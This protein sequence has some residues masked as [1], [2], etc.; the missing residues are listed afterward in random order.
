MKN[1]LLILFLFMSYSGY[2]YAAATRAIQADLW[3]SNDLSKTFT[4]P[5]V[6]DTLVGVSAT[7]TIQGKTMS[8]TANTFSNVA[9]G[10]F[11]TGN[12]SGNASATSGVQATTLLSNFVG[13][14]GSGGTKGLVPAPIAGDSGKYLKGDGTWGTV[15]AGVGDMVLA[16]SQTVTGAKSFNLNTLLLNGTT[17]S[18]WLNGPAAGA[19]GTVTLP[20][21]GTV[22]TLAGTETLTNKTVSTSTIIV[23]DDSLTIQD[24]VTPTKKLQLQVSSVTAGN[25]RTLTAPDFDGT[26]VTTATSQTLTDKTLTNPLISGVAAS[27]LINA[28]TVSGAVVTVGD[29]SLTVQNGTKKAQ[30]DASVISSGATRSFQ[31]PDFSGILATT[32]GSETLTNKTVSTSTIVVN[33]NVF[34]VQDDATPTKKLQLQV[35]G[36]TAGTTRT[37]SVP[38]FSNTIATTSGTET[39]TNKTVSTSTI[40]VND[41]VLTVQDNATP[42]KKLQFEV[43]GLTA[44]ATRTLTAPD[45]NGVIACV[46]CT[47]TF[48]NKS[49]SEAQLT[50]T[51]ITTGN[52]NTSNHGFVPKATNTGTQF[53]RDDGTWAA[54]TG[55][56]GDMVLATSQTV[57][58]AKSFNQNTLLL[59][60]TTGSTWLNG[61][62]AGTSTTITLPAW[63]GTVVTAATSQTITDKTITTP[64]IAGATLSGTISGTPTLS[65]NW[66]ANALTLNQPSILNGLVSGTNYYGTNAFAAGSKI[67]GFFDGNMSVSGVW[68]ASA[69]NAFT[70]SNGNVSGGTV[71]AAT[72]VVNDDALTLQDTAGPTKKLQF[73]ASGITAGQTRVLSAPDFDGTLVTLATSQTLTDKTLTTPTINGATLSGIVSGAA[74]TFYGPIAFEGVVSGSGTVSGAKIVVKDSEF[75]LQDATPTRKAQFELNTITAGQVRVMT[76]PDF[77]GTLATTATSQTLTDK[78]LTTPLI[79]GATM[80]ALWGGSASATGSASMTGFINVNPTVSGVIT[81]NDNL[82]IA[83]TKGIDYSAM[84]TSSTSTASQVCDDYDFNPGVSMTLTATTTSGTPTY[85]ANWMTYEKKCRHVH[86]DAY[87]SWSA[88][89]SGAGNIRFVLPYTAANLNTNYRSSCRVGYVDNL[90]QTASTT[91]AIVV[92]PG[93]YASVYAIPVSGTT[94]AVAY[95]PSGLVMFSCDYIGL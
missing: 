59:N 61:P 54:P 20:T 63:T 84:A 35:S 57:T 80:G 33:D 52:V 74:T 32:S 23:N 21:T 43:S 64:S 15:A 76:I 39:L 10:T 83:S 67:S 65:G 11:V 94:A 1:I 29:S 87:V 28:G 37:L 53:L 17:G 92:N 7:Q 38:D 34:T 77:S 8:I 44:G 13:D 79:N 82:K 70:L 41:D 2:S 58:G 66:T 46:S 45:D 50:F 40:I 62:A 60:G 90:S 42:T 78:T 69:A 3:L 24:N 95:D 71:S 89:S 19:S 49:M 36:L 22:A 68:T 86:L 81:V 93:I 47:Q 16:T 72:I 14:S 51:D 73:N 27:T 4:P 30:F 31:F 9:S 85:T 26:I 25:T 88:W 6:S 12:G 48:T 55:G 75:T 56:A 18:T 5:G 91:L